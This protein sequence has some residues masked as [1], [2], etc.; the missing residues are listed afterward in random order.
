MCVFAQTR[1]NAVVW[2]WQNPTRDEVLVVLGGEGTE[3]ESA[4]HRWLMHIQMEPS[5]ELG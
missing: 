3:G 5:D 4:L 1:Y 2:K